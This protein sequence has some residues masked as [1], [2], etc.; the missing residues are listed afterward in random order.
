MFF[1]GAALCLSLFWF[2]RKK[3]H[4]TI[5]GF[6]AVIGGASLAYSFLGGWIIALLTWI[7]G[8]ITGLFP[9]PISPNSVVAAVCVFVLVL[10]VTDVWKDKKLDEHGQWAAI[11]LPVLLLAAGGGVGAT[12]ATVVDGIAG[13]GSNI[14]GP[15]LGW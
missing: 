4:W 5:S 12:G 9:E 6:L 11:C 13:A 15:V 14:F 7:I 2:V 10:V 1:V 3:A 8:F